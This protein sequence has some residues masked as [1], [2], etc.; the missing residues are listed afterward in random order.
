MPTAE[1]LVTIAGMWATGRRPDVAET[2]TGHQAT[3]IDRWFLDQML[4]VAELAAESASVLDAELLGLAK[5]RGL[6][7]EQIGA[8]RAATASS[9]ACAGSASTRV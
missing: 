4:L 5:R 3:A 1:R 2:S 9:R 8:H 7:D 6:S